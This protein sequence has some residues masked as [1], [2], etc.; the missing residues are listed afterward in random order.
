MTTGTYCPNAVNKA[1]A[2]RAR[3]LPWSDL[4]AFETRLPEIE[5]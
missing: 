1:A 5:S 2:K 4:Q 3:G